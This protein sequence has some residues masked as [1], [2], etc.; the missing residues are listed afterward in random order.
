MIRRDNDGCPKCKT[1]G[2]RVENP[3]MIVNKETLDDTVLCASCRFFAYTEA[4][5][6][7]TVN[8]STPDVT[9]EQY[10]KLNSK[11]K[12]ETLLTIRDV[13]TLKWVMS[14]EKVKWVR[15]RAASRVRKY[16]NKL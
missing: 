11:Q 8:P 3:V 15:N 16:H 10:Q 4:Q 1:C 9:I 2:S 6:P 12:Y 14:N 7:L 13:Q 5:L